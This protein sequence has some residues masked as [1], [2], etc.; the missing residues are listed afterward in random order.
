M[1]NSNRDQARNWQRYLDLIG[2][3]IVPA[4]EDEGPP[5]EFSPGE[6]ESLAKLEHERWMREKQN[7]GWSYAPVRDNSA[8]KH[9]DLLPWEQ[10]SEPVRDK[11]RE[12]IR[13]IPAALAPAGFCVRRLSRSQQ[14]A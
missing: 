14:P 10:L 9:P 4:A 12:A 5:F 2:G 11:D 3:V 1:Q 13:N 6:I 8:K 7:S